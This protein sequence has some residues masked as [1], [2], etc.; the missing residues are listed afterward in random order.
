MAPHRPCGPTLPERSC[1]LKH[2]DARSY[3]FS[4]PHSPRESGWARLTPQ[5]LNSKAQGREADAERTLGQ[6]TMFRKTL[7]GFY[8]DVVRDPSG[9]RSLGVCGGVLLSNAGRH[10][11]LNDCNTLPGYGSEALS[12]PGCAS[13]RKARIR[14]PGLRCVTPTAW[15]IRW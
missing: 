15:K 11:C 1:S 10:A 9:C 8:N 5:A 12:F 6:P 7:P 14:D 13:A 2:Y 3:E 4:S